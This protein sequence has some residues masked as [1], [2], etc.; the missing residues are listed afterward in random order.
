[1]EKGALGYILMLAGAPSARVPPE[2]VV[3]LPDAEPFRST[4]SR[5]LGVMW[6]D[7]ALLIWR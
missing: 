7:A 5:A 6:S 4:E 3:V 2:Q 1:M